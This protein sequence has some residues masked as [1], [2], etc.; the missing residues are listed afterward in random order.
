MF[1]NT[2]GSPLR[3]RQYTCSSGSFQADFIVI[4]ISPCFCGNA[5]VVGGMTGADIGR[6]AELAGRIG[7]NGD[8]GTLPADYA[9][10]NVSAKV[11]TLIQS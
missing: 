10:T 3:L 1:A 2:G 6:A 5:V 7:E 8:A 9:G 11:V 4:K